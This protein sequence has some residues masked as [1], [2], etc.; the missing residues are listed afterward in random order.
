MSNSY[1]QFKQFVVH[2]DRC[3]MKVGTDGVLLGAWADVEH[4][5]RIL[6][7]GTG[8]GL[9]SLML[10]QRNANAS[11]VGIE[12]DKN[13]ADQAEE[14]VRLSPFS[15][16]IDIRRISFQEF[17]AKTTQR[18]DYLI[19]NPPF[20]TDSLPSPDHSRSLARHSDTLTLEELFCGAKQVAAEHAR[21][22]VII[23][24][25]QK[26]QTLFA[27]SDFGWRPARITNVF[28][29]LHSKYPKRILVEFMNDV[30]DL[31]CENELTIEIRS[32]EYSSEYMDL[33]KDFYL[34]SST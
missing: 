5:H 24:Y 34:L 28:S 7:I 19:S 1:F 10:A 23:P 17:S 15:E 18:F 14:N 16:R 26:R 31:I 30:P 21:F 13:A 27:A 20:F 8:T 9:I 2:Q 4:A 32:K 6:D 11:I 29:L 33:V 22:S 25:L 12:I 3:A